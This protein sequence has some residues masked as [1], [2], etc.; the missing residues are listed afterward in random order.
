MDCG[1]RPAPSSAGSSSSTSPKTSPSA[2]TP[3]VARPPRAIGPLELARHRR[4]LRVLE[5]ARRD[6]LGERRGIEVDVERVSVRRHPARHVHADG[7]DL[8][9]ALSV[10]GRHPHAGQAVVAHSV[11]LEGAERP[12]ERL[13]E[14][15]H[16][17]LDVLPVLVAGRGSGSRRAVPGRGR[18]TCRRGRSRRSRPL[19]LGDVE[20][21]VRLGAAPDRDDGRVL[22]EDDRL[23]DRALRDRPGE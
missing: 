3:Q 17:P 23:R 5:P 20:L 4:E 7:R 19:R 15:A 1:Q 6:P 21:A 11:E 12:D 14:V 8:S 2:A 10:R 16:V 9:W 13:L 18:S 22:E